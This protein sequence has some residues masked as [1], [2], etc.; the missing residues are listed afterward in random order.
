[1]LYAGFI[2][3]TCWSKPPLANNLSLPFWAL[4]NSLFRS[5]S[6][7]TL[8]HLQSVDFSIDGLLDV[9]QSGLLVGTPFHPA[10]VI[11]AQSLHQG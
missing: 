11:D 6:L 9:Y 5:F 8:T 3:S 1:M 2:V 7:T 10:L 4:R